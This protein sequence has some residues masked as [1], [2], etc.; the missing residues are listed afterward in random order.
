MRRTTD[1]SRCGGSRRNRA[2]TIEK[3]MILMEKRENKICCLF[4][5]SSAAEAINEWYGEVVE[6]LTDTCRHD[7]ILYR[8]RKCGG[9]VLRDYEETALFL[10]GEDWDNAYIDEYYYPVLEEDIEKKDGEMSFNWSALISRKHIAASYRELDEGDKPYYYVKAKPEKTVRKEYTKECP[11]TEVFDSLPAEKQRFDDMCIFI[12][13]PEYPT[14]RNLKLQLPNHD[15]PQEINVSYSNGDYRMELIFPMDDFGWQ[16]PLVLAAEGMSF[17][18]VKQVL[19]EILIYQTET[20]DIELITERFRDVTTEV[21][22]EDSKE[23]VQET[24]KDRKR[25]HVQEILHNMSDEEFFKLDPEDYT[26]Y[27]YDEIKRWYADDPD[28]P[29][30]NEYSFLP[31]PGEWDTWAEYLHEAACKDNPIALALFAYFSEN[32]ISCEKD[33]ETAYKCYA[34]GAELGEVHCVRALNR[35]RNDRCPD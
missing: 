9:L 15:D 6:N 29:V 17:D 5:G 11:V 16:H 14:P 25:K 12:Q 21:Y 26:D 4:Q 35:I 24:Q 32:G 3:G 31:K 18:D 23:N 33:L 1:T 13:I 19:T 7:R 20:G 28:R 22:G 8:C 34:R 30:V 27:D 10:P 2:S